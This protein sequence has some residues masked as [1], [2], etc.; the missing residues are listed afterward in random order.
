[1]PELRIELHEEAVA[2]ARAAREWYGARSEA[3]AEAFMVELGQAVEQIAKFPEAWP[4][5]VSN[6]RR[7]LLQRFPFSIVYRRR[8]RIVQVIAVAHNRRRP[9]YWKNRA[10]NKET[11][12]AIS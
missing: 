7:Y 1:M 4:P 12:P 5:Y 2:E 8:R 3:A 9:G 11:Q 10:G 6:T